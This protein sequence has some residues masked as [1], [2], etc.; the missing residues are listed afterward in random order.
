VATPGFIRTVPGPARPCEMAIIELGLSAPCAGIALPSNK[1]VQHSAVWQRKPPVSVPGHPLSWPSP[2]DPLRPMGCVAAGC[3]VA[4]LH[5]SG[6]VVHFR[7]SGPITAPPAGR[8]ALK[9]FAGRPR[10]RVRA[11][12]EV[13]QFGHCCYRATLPGR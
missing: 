5:A 6:Q 8:K 2:V 13:P 1:R 3:N 11:A 12:A 10:F 7:R 9:W 4:A